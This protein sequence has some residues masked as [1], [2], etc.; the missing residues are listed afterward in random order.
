[1]EDDEEDVEQE[2]ERN[3]ETRAS[4]GVGAQTEVKEVMEDDE[5][6]VE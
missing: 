1:M 6:D 2:L 4:F 3:A 5:A